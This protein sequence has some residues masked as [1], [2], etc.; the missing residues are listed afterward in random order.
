M[1]NP[2]PKLF[3][4]EEGGWRDLRRAFG[5]RAQATLG[6]NATYRVGESLPYAFRLP[7]ADAAIAHVTS[8][9]L[10]AV[11]TRALIDGCRRHIFKHG[12]TRLA[13]INVL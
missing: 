12:Y 8:P 4:Y 3:P 10:K 6:V 11:D 13:G 5:S 1:S 2:S 7:A 9:A